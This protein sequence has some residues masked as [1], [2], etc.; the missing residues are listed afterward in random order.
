[1]NRVICHLV[2]LCKEM[3]RRRVREYRRRSAVFIGSWDLGDG[4]TVFQRM[5]WGLAA[6][7][8]D[9]TVMEDMSKPRQRPCR[10]RYRSQLVGI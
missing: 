1:M 8:T 6:A 10:T 9:R 5:L 7:T 4:T 2:L 3:L